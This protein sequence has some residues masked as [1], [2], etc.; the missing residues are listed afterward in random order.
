[1][2]CVCVFEWNHRTHSTFGCLR[3]K[4]FRNCVLGDCVAGL[5]FILLYGVLGLL[6]AARRNTKKRIL[7]FPG[8]NRLNFEY[9]HSKHRSIR[10][11][12]ISAIL[13]NSGPECIPI[14]CEIFDIVR[15]WWSWF[16]SVH[17]SLFQSQ[18]AEENTKILC[19]FTFKFHENSI[20]FY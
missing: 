1:M 13:D 11:G 15:W 9:K 16:H 7:S 17:W 10:C 12:I 14:P 18:T 8:L 4:R 20:I 2:F 6:F 19:F 3:R 5:L